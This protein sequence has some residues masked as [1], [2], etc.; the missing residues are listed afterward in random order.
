MG[1]IFLIAWELFAICAYFNIT[2]DRQQRETRAAG[3]LY[4][5]AS[6]AGTLCLF[7]FFSLLA[8]RTG[9]WDLGP[10]RENAGLAP[11]VLAGPVRVRHQ[12]GIFPVAHLVAIGPCQ[13]AKPR[14]RY[15]V[16]RRNQDGPLTASCVFSGWLPV[17]PTAGWV[18]ISFCAISAFVG[19]AFAL[20]QNDFKRLL[21]YCSVENMGIILIGL[22]AALLAITLAV[23]A[24]LG[25]PG[26]GRGV[27]A[28]LESCRVQIPFVLWCRLGLACHGHARN[29]PPRRIMAHNAMDCRAVRPF[30]RGLLYQDCLRSM[31]LSVNG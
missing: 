5:A 15:H 23:S 26:H 21:A 28:R 1:C 16:R 14:L 18:V 31:G 20:V 3:W 10:M 29:E 25:L 6:H 27:A 9:S 13:C 2:L 8:V 7:A 12:S 17:P 22:G 4:L 30:W 19:I 11:A 24:S